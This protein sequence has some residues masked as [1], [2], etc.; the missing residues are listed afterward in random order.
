MVPKHSLTQVLKTR[1]HNRRR[2][3]KFFFKNELIAS[4]LA[5]NMLS[6]KYKNF[7]LWVTV[8]YLL[9]LKMSTML[10][11]TTTYQHPFFSALGLRWIWGGR[12]GFQRIFSKPRQQLY[13]CI[14]STLSLPHN[15]KLKLKAGRILKCYKVANC[16][17]IKSCCRVACVN[18]DVM[19]RY[20]LSVLK[21]AAACPT[22]PCYTVSTINTA[23]IRWHL[24][25]TTPV[26]WLLNLN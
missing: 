9:W 1:A 18:C 25:P 7:G 4:Q 24:T 11:S 26:T 15:D 23:I 3:Q 20:E 17:L 5:L 19:I 8:L 16:N 22:A 2:P 14:I 21:T 13:Y 10:V 6:L 12:R